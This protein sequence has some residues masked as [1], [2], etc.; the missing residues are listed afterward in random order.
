M[1]PLARLR[2]RLFEDPRS[3]KA[4][5]RAAGT[6]SD[7]F[8]DAF[9]LNEVDESAGDERRARGE[10]P[11]KREEREDEEKLGHAGLDRKTSESR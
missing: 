9:A 10:A 8:L 11:V 4:G 5:G 2:V 3:F 7:S 6:M 1:I